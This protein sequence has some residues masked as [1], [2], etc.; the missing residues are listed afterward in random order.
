MESPSTSRRSTGLILW[1]ATIIAIILPATWRGK[2]DTPVATTLFVG[3][4]SKAERMRHLELV[5]SATGPARRL[6][7]SWAAAYKDVLVY[8][9]SAGSEHA[10]SKLCATCTTVHVYA[11]RSS[12]AAAASPANRTA[13]LPQHEALHY[14]TH[15]VQRYDQLSEMTAFLPSQAPEISPDLL[16]LLGYLERWSPVQPLG[17]QRPEGA[18]LLRRRSGSYV[19][20]PGA[21]ARVAVVRNDR[22]FR[23]VGDHAGSFVAAQ[24]P[25]PWVTQIYLP[26][27]DDFDY[28]DA[29]GPIASPEGSAVVAGSGGD[30]DSPSIPVGARGLLNDEL[31]ARPDSVASPLCAVWDVLHLGTRCPETI[32]V[33]YRNSFAVSRERILRR[34]RSFYLRLLEWSQANEANG[35]ALERLW[36]SVFGYTPVNKVAGNNVRAAAAPPEAGMPAG[37]QHSAGLKVG[38][39]GSSPPPP[40]GEFEASPPPMGDLEPIPPPVGD[41]KASPPPVGDLKASPP[42]VGDLEASPPR[43]GDLKASPPPVG[44][45]KASPPPV[46][47]LEASPFLVGDLEATLPPTDMY[48]ISGD[49]GERR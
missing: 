22:N 21:G 42:P 1:L 18:H 14:L 49:Y 12:A 37:T 7:L 30:R 13:P 19:G 43:V 25:E 46:G 34:P 16:R 10:H 15:I 20:S 9:S 44:D 26:R 8:H 11:G 35:L 17:W 6:N 41:L 48:P 36:L 40:V 3:N 47:D 32:L 31:G 39:P 4:S 33:N 38:D 5:L 45:L 24:D 29:A 23:L 27:A 28:E 2:Y